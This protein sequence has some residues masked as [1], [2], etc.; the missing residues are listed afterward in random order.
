MFLLIPHG[1]Q[2]HTG[3]NYSVFCCLL[4]FVQID[5]RG[6]LRICCL[7]WMGQAVWVLKD[8]EHLSFLGPGQLNMELGLLQ[9]AWQIV[10]RRGKPGIHNDGVWLGKVP[11]HSKMNLWTPL[12]WLRTALTQNLDLG[13]KSRKPH[14]LSVCWLF[15][16]FRP[17]WSFWLRRPLCQCWLPDRVEVWRAVRTRQ[18][19]PL[20]PPHFAASSQQTCAQHPSLIGNPSTKLAL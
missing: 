8:W 14:I 15:S 7:G 12:S 11:T 16:N 13:L 9:G 17:S 3:T 20:S 5:F 2:W 1:G 6:K 19:G 4:F 18:W 10:L